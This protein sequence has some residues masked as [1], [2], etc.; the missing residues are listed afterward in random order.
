VQTATPLHTSRAAP[1]L[2]VQAGL[3]AN[4]AAQFFFPFV[5]GLFFFFPLRATI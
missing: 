2:D 5:H 3:I 1:A 4:A